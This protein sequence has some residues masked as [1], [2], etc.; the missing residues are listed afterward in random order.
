MGERERKQSSLDSAGDLLRL[1]GPGLFEPRWPL[2]PFITRHSAGRNK[3][4]KK[5]VLI[6]SLVHLDHLPTLWTDWT[7]LYVNGVVMF[8][9]LSR[10]QA[11]NGSN[12]PSRSLLLAMFFPATG[13]RAHTQFYF[14]PK[15]KRHNRR[16]Q[17]CAWD[18]TRKDRLACE[19]R[20]VLST[21]SQCPS[22]P[23]RQSV[24]G[25]HWRADVFVLLM[26]FG[27]AASTQW[28]AAS[29]L[30]FIVWSLLI[31]EAENNNQHHPALLVYTVQLD[32]H[33]CI[34]GYYIWY[35]LYRGDICSLSTRG[36]A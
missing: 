33:V 22:C 14:V 35:T 10:F 15:A 27:A 16:E 31:I 30:C 28:T 17:T 7:P 26:H 32:R 12:C 11:V 3:E 18:K 20:F 24:H 19:W 5:L 36:D 25:G 21:A 6:H 1:M 4:S 9:F 23:D 2:G 13:P 29:P 8:W 34:S